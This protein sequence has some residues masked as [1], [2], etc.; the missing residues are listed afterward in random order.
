[1]NANPFALLDGLLADWVSPKVRRIIHTILFL[2][3][4]VITIVLAAGGDWREALLTLFVA[5][6]TGANRAN[7]LPSEDDYDTD[8]GYIHDPQNELDAEDELDGADEG[9]DPALDGDTTTPGI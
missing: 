7:T 6:Y 5:F 2:I 8:E 9:G 4:T 1:M 3:A